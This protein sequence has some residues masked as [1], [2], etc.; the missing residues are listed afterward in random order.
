[1]SHVSGFARRM[2]RRF[3]GP[4]ALT[5]GVRLRDEGGRNAL[6]MCEWAG[7]VAELDDP[8]AASGEG[9]KGFFLANG[10]D[11]LRAYLTNSTQ[12]FGGGGAVADQV[13]G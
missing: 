10:F 2:R 11:G 13:G 3:E 7:A 9:G 1:M 6:G 12:G 8:V 4:R 5:P